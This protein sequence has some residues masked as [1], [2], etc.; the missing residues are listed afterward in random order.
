MAAN[1]YGLPGKLLNF[2]LKG[3]MK[4]DKLHNN[5]RRTFH[6]SQPVSTYAF[7]GS[8]RRSQVSVGAKSFWLTKMLH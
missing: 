6:I 2:T 5:Q 1:G 3:P 7:S 4:V 8:L